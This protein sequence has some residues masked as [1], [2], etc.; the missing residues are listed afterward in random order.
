MG[1]EVRVHIEMQEQQ[2]RIPV[3]SKEEIGKDLTTNYI[4]EKNV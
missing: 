3:S 1:G 2:S 4:G